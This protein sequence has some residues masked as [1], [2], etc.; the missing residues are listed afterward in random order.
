M[1][2]QILHYA[3]HLPAHFP[4]DKRTDRTQEDLFSGLAGNEC[5]LAIPGM[6]YD[7]CSCTLPKSP[8]SGMKRPLSQLLGV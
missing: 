2:F 3:N 8:S 7:R 1:I 6:C 5:I 4:Q